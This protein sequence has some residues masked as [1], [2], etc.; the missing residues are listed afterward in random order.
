MKGV[1]ET[2]TILQLPFFAALIDCL[3]VPGY[4]LCA[5]LNI[6][7]ESSCAEEVPCWIFR[8]IKDALRGPET[9]IPVFDLTL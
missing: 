4:I 1:C 5:Q 6:R 8:T 9:T 7:Q 3:C 2:L